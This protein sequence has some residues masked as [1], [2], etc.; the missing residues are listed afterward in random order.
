MNVQKEKKNQ[1]PLK[2]IIIR[3][4]TI[5]VTLQI[6]VL[7]ITKKKN[8]FLKYIFFSKTNFKNN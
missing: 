2:I 4:Y 6:Y 3:C 1:R 7:S 8:P 5:S